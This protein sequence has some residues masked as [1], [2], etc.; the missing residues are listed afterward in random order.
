[1]SKYMYFKSALKT[2]RKPCDFLHMNALDQN[3]N[4][5]QQNAGSKKIRVASKFI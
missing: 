4:S 2:I 1:M 3:I 5:I